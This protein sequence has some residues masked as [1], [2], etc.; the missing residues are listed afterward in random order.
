MTVL[1]ILPL[2]S[3]PAV[4]GRLMLPSSSVKFGVPKPTEV[5]I[6]VPLLPSVVAKPTSITRS[7]PPP[8][9]EP[10]IVINSK[11]T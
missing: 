10:G 8:K 9:V 6:N 11:S 3:S 2:S 7:A 1:R 4:V 5:I